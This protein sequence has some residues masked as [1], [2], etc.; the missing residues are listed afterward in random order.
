MFVKLSLN[1]PDNRNVW[2]NTD[3]VVLLEPCGRSFNA[4]LSD[5]NA[6]VLDL[7]QYLVLDKA[8]KIKEQVKLVKEIPKEVVIPEISPAVT[9]KA[10]LKRAAVKEAEAKTLKKETGEGVAGGKPKTKLVKKANKKLSEHK[11]P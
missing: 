4:C 7:V 10:G 1:K 3:H 11:R 9:D 5:G 8:M 2:V 6:L